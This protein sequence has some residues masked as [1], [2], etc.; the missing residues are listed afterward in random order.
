[1]FCTC[2]GWL[3]EGRSGAGMLLNMTSGLLT[4]NWISLYGHSPNFRKYSLWL[5]KR[6]ETEAREGPDWG[7]SGVV[8]GMH[9]IPT[10]QGAPVIEDVLMNIFSSSRF[11]RPSRTPPLGRPGCDDAVL[12]V[13]D[14]CNFSLSGNTEASPVPPPPLGAGLEQGGN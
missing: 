9:C 4:E 2:G 14:F 5:G 7:W 6:G 11:L 3:P 10:L 1:M 8:D 13:R 12:P